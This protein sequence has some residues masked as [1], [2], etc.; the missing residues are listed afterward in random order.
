MLLLLANATVA[1]EIVTLL[2]KNVLDV[3]S[4]FLGKSMIEMAHL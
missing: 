1:Q 2:C 4:V 3:G